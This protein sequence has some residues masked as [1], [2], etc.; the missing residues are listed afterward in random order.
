MEVTLAITLDVPLETFIQIQGSRSRRTAQTFRLDP[1]V[2]GFLSAALQR[3]DLSDVS[4]LGDT[5]R[6]APPPFLKAL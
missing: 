4:V 2:S 1:L 3:Q 6:V 5:S